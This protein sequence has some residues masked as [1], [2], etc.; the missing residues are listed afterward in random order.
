MSYNPMSSWFYSKFRQGGRPPITTRKTP[1]RNA[2]RRN[3][4]NQPRTTVL[5]AITAPLGFFVLAL[6]IV[7]TFLATILIGANFEPLQKLIGM[8]AGVGMFVL[9]TLLVFLLV[10]FKP[11]NLTFDKHA[12]LLDRG[13]IRYGKETFPIEPER[14]LQVDE[15]E[16]EP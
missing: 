13:K 6:L 9:V 15:K 14:A 16:G 10:W 12:H 3:D 1:A 7:E 2:K 8:W 5:E 4:G 11:S